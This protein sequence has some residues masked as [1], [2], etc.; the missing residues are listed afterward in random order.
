MY[1]KKNVVDESARY[2]CWYLLYRYYNTERRPE[3][4]LVCRLAYANR[5]VKQVSVKFVRIIGMS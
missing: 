2:W 5:R 1:R 4:V 3:S